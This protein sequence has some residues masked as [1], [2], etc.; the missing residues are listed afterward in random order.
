[1]NFKSKSG[2][3][4]H[5][6]NLYNDAVISLESSE[7]NTLLIFEILTSTTEDIYVRASLE[8]FIMPNIDTFR[9]DI[10]LLI[11]R[12]YAI[13]GNIRDNEI[14]LD[15]VDWNYLKH[16]LNQLNEVG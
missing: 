10:M 5:N 14:D 7:I 9:S 12:W 13:S 1:M 16:L 3:D 8:A 2:T 11:N 15:C 6:I 4:Y